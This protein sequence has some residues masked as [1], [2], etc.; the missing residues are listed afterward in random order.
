MN[1]LKFTVH[2]QL[3]I[4]RSED[5]VDLSSVVCKIQHR[6]VVVLRRLVLYP[7]SLPKSSE[8]MDLAL[9]GPVNLHMRI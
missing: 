7:T 3:K 2:V 5:L 6:I 9:I 8:S 4:E 1:Q